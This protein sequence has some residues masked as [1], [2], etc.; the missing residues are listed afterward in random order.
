MNGSLSYMSGW[1]APVAGCL[2][3]VLT[4]H[5]FHMHEKVPYS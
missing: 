1:V 5:G 3:E 4:F 2:E